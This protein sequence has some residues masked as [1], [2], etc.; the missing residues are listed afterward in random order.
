MGL[1]ELLEPNKNIKKPPVKLI[2]F[3]NEAPKF[4]PNNLAALEK[5]ARFNQSP[6]RS[7][8][9]GGMDLLF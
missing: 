9:S 4:S 1:A 7:A 8:G 5:F 3:N 2:K 6:Q